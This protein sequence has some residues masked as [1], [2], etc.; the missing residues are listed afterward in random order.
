MRN[1]DV[2]KASR[3]EARNVVTS[4]ACS[5]GRWYWKKKNAAYKSMS[6]FQKRCA[7]KTYCV[8]HSAVSSTTECVGLL[9]LTVTFHLD[10]LPV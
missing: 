8:Q 2:L 4:Y 7:N 3:S 6:F 1:V 9:E 10:P 5:R